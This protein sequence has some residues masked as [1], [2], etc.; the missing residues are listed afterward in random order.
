VRGPATQF[1]VTHDRGRTWTRRADL[2]ILGINQCTLTV[3]DLDPNVVAAWGRAIPLHSGGLAVSA[4]A[5][6]ASSG[7]ELIT[8]DGGISWQQ[9]SWAINGGYSVSQLA[10]RDGVTYAAFCCAAHGPGLQLVVSRDRMATWQPIDDALVTAGQH[11][12]RFDLNPYTGVLLAITLD[13]TSDS[14]APQLLWQSADAGAHWTP[15]AT[16][17]TSPR[18]TY[19]VEHPGANQP[20]KICVALYPP[21]GN[22]DTSFLVPSMLTCSIDGGRSWQESIALPPKAACQPPTEG[23][24]LLAIAANG[25]L[26]MDDGG[27]TDTLYRLASAGG[28]WQVVAA[29]PTASLDLAYYPT[30]GF[31]WAVPRIVD[32]YTQVDP[33]GHVYSKPLAA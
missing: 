29:A 23:P 16:P 25:D 20:A 15:L 27:C 24:R 6:A 1:W 5:S 3:D 2:P 17:D 18:D 26:Y 4:R 9:P 31:L 10:T 19:V 14:G 32:P 13:N 22:T 28:T 33:T 30:T 11:I 7:G 21:D 12:D 8:L